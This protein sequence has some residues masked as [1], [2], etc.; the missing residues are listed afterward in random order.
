[1]ARLSLSFLRKLQVP[2]RK[3]RDAWS[4]LQTSEDERWKN[5]VRGRPTSHEGL[6]DASESDMATE[7]PPLLAGHKKRPTGATRTPGESKIE[8]ENESTPGRVPTLSELV[9]RR[10]LENKLADPEGLSKGA[11][12]E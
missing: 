12:D 3:L 4:I 11:A 8:P 2:I 6:V 5:S 1:M 10:Q 7:A 9:V